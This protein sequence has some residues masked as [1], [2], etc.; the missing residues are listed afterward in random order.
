M[1]PLPL[2]LASL[3]AGCTAIGP[4]A[5]HRTRLSYNETVKVTSE[6]EML[7]NIVRLRYGD[8]P[9]SL[10][11]TNIAAQYELSAGLGASPFFVA[12]AERAFTSVLPQA[13]VGGADRPTLSLTPLDDS[14]FARRLFTP[15]SLE[16]VIYLAKTTWPIETV[17]RLYLENLNWVPNAQSASGPTPAAAPPPSGFN[18]GLRALQL[19]QQ[20]GDVVFGT[21][22]H[23][24]QFGP[25]VA[26]VSSEHLLAAAQQGLEFVEQPGG[27]SWR[28][29]RKAPRY[30]LRLNPAA[31]ESKEMATFRRAFHLKPGVAHFHV[32]VEALE[33]FAAG[34][35][36]EQ[37]DLETRSLLQALF[38]V[39]H[40]VAVP[41][42]HL[43]GGL[44]RQTKHPDGRRYDWNAE[45]AGLFSVK[46]LPGSCAPESAHVAIEYAEHC[47]FIEA[48]DQDT[49]A[50]FSLLME[51][52]R[53]Q[54]ADKAGRAGP[55]LTIPL[56][57]R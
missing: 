15:L 56:G 27:K 4:G 53:L 30:V 47:F 13:N 33:P 17:F 14:E 21:E 38:Y 28:L 19:L 20:R 3:L 35:E 55:M 54:L 6:Q 39:S 50:T 16:G 22:P 40:G 10:A 12:G 29:Q 8:T 1:R 44:A 46:S 5:L 48:T 26:T 9:S 11:I 25:P 24:E 45:L 37:L 2:V 31:L 52:A 18:E 51:L 36:L 7:L 23:A 41:D 49:K 34:Q 43:A 32:T 42:E 57:G